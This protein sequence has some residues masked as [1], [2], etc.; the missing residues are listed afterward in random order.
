MESTSPAKCTLTPFLHGFAP[1]V[2]CTFPNPS[3][4]TDNVVLS[5]HFDSRGSFGETRAPGGDDDASG[6]AHLLAVAEALGRSGVVFGKNV[7]FAFFAGE[8][9]G[10]LGSHAFAGEW[11]ISSQSYLTLS[12]QSNCTKRM[13]LSFFTFKRTC[14]VIML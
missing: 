4:S 13:P 9:Q 3:N 11:T 6:S 7:T 1:N 12:T 2:I 8:E 14:S 10:L 5:G